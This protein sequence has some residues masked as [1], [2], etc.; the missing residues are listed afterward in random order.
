MVVLVALTTLAMAARQNYLA[1]VTHAVYRNG[2]Q[3]SRGGAATAWRGR[4]NWRKMP[5]SWRRCRRFKASSTPGAASPAT[6]RRCGAGGWKQSFPACCEPAGLP[7]GL[8][9]SETG[10][11]AADIVRVERNPADPSLIRVLPQSRLQPRRS[12]RADEGSRGAR[13]GRCEVVA[14]SAGA[15]ARAGE[16]GAAERRHAC[17]TAT[18]RANASA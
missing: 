2:Q 4:G 14:R 1:A 5:A 11:G 16:H 17:L 10:G 8:V 9:R 7:G 15:A 6:T 3:C 12:G 13:A 18:S